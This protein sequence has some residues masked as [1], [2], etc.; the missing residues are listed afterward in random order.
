MNLD[1]RRDALN[2]ADHGQTGVRRMHLFAAALALTASAMAIGV[3]PGLVVIG[4]HVGEF[5]GRTALTCGSGTLAASSERWSAV[6]AYF[7]DDTGIMKLTVV[8]GAAALTS[9]GAVR[10]TDAQIAAAL[11][12][13]DMEYTVV[14]Q[15]KFTT[16]AGSVVAVAVIDHVVQSQGVDSSGKAVTSGN[17]QVGGLCYRPW[18]TLR[19]GPVPAPELANADVVTTLPLPLIYGRIKSWRAVCTSA[20]T[21]VAKTCTLTPKINTTAITSAATAY[22]GAKAIGAVTA[23]G[24]PTAANTFKPGDT[25]TL[26]G[27]A[28]TAFIEGAVAIELEIEED[29]ARAA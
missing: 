19:I 28:T 5:D 25:F 14:G 24:T 22:A 11:P 9:A 21:T 10:V 13:S 2:T 16:T 17:E 7:N 18:G 8:D 3:S 4:D 12:E 26:T 23:L 27:S 20:I 1:T 15:V 29:V 6:V